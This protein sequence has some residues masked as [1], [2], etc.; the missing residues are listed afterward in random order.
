MPNLA[1]QLG[2]YEPLRQ[3]SFRMYIVN[4]GTAGPRNSEQFEISIRDGFTPNRTIEEIE[5]DVE[6]EK[7]YYAGKS[8]YDAG[9]LVARDYVDAEVCRFIDDWHDAIFN[10]ATGIAGYKTQYA[11]E[12]IIQQYA[13]DGSV[14]REWRLKNIWPTSIDHGAITHGSAEPVE[15]S[16]S[17]RYDRAIKT[18]G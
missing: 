9:S 4:T 17:F 3:H 18:V 16:V 7:L 12:A 10:P 13:P 5:I 8:T 6:N 1:D 15:I 14:V 2:A 11:G